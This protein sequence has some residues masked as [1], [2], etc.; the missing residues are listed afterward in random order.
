MGTGTKGLSQH[1]AASLAVAKSFNTAKEMPLSTV[2]NKFTIVDKEFFLDENGQSGFCA[3]RKFRSIEQI[4]NFLSEASGKS[5]VY[6]YKLFELSQYGFDLE[7]TGKKFYH[8]RYCIRS[9]Q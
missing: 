9:K 5:K 2:G 4:K 8:F 3:I 7:P 1:I 6:A